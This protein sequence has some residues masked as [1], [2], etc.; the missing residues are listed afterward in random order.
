LQQSGAKEKMKWNR[1]EGGWQQLKGN[2]KR[3]WRRLTNIDVIAGNR[4]QL[5]LN[6]QERYGITNDEAEKQLADW[7]GRQKESDRFA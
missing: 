4:E 3:R 6:I 5:A 2:F 1:I 7:Q